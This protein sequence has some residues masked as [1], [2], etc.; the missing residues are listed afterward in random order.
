M[1]TGL[2][3]RG[4]A[5]GSSYGRKEVA[6]AVKR[7]REAEGEGKGKKEENA[8]AGESGRSVVK[9][10][11]DRRVSDEDCRRHVGEDEGV[12]ILVVWY[13][14]EEVVLSKKGHQ[15]EFDSDR[16]KGGERTRSCSRD[17]SKLLVA[18]SV[19]RSSRACRKVMKKEARDE[20]RGRGAMSSG[21]G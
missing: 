5:A 18:I 8:H 20:R 17:C 9:R 19:V 12:G 4:S 2:F 11:L 14:S 16:E 21:K 7:H 3:R 1:R 10:S 15:R 13:L 6:G